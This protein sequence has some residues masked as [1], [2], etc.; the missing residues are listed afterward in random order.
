LCRCAGGFGGAIRG[1][2]HSQ[3]GVG[4]HHGRGGY[5][6]VSDGWCSS[7]ENCSTARGSDCREDDLGDGHLSGKNSGREAGGDCVSCRDSS[8]LC[9]RHG[10]DLRNSDS[11]DWI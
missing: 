6:S 10:Y 9:A 7:D 11:G 1:G 4:W 8:S 2:G 5:T 3:G